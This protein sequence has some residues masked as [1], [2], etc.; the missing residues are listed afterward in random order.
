MMIP[1]YKPCPYCGDD[2]PVVDIDDYGKYRIM[3]SNPSCDAQPVCKSYDTV[4]DAV[5]SWNMRV[6][7]AIRTDAVRCR[8]CKYC[9]KFEDVTMNGDENDTW[10]C[11]KRSAYYNDGYE[12]VIIVDHENGCIKGEKKE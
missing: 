7:S 6:N 2:L 12:D 10:Y 8:E 3:C 1:D 11:T 5:I 9:A 4:I